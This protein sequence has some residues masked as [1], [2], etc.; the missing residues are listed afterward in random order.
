MEH[1]AKG[2]VNPSEANNKVDDAAM[3]PLMDVGAVNGE[4]GTGLSAPELESIEK[5]EMLPDAP[6][7]T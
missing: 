5:P 6:F 7:A 2:A 4:P 3:L 1:T